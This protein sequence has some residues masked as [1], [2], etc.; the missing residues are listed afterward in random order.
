MRIFRALFRILIGLVF[1]LVS[2]IALAPAFAAFTADEDSA[3][4]IV[5]LLLITLCCVFCFF[6]PTIRRAFGRGFLVAGA[7]VFALPIS[8]FLLSG[9][10]ASEVMQSAEKGSE[11]LTAVGAG[12]AGVAI[13]G[14]AT[15][16]GVIVGA[17]LLITGAIL[18]LG[19]RR[20][21]TIHSAIQPNIA[22][23]SP[24]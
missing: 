18:S 16:F 6:A 22:Q 20:E 10:A 7:A 8:T 11:A 3:T 9:K 21:V 23:K 5:M 14:I 4:P 15:L 2:T 12:F 1:G 19:G 24:R 13:T 17:I